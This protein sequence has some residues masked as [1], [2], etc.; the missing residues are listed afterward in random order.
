MPNAALVSAIQLRDSSEIQITPTCP[1]DAERRLRLALTAEVRTLM[2]SAAWSGG[3]L[4]LQ[5]VPFH[6]LLEWKLTLITNKFPGWNSIQC[7]S[8][9][10]QLSLMCPKGLRNKLQLLS[11]PFSHLHRLLTKKF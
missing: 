1:L 6:L 8:E 2:D 7:S 11:L 10:Y 5:D 9:V 4:L 3:C